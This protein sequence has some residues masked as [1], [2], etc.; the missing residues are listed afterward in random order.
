MIIFIHLPI[1]RVLKEISLLWQQT[2]GI[3]H[4][5]GHLTVFP[6]KTQTPPS[7]LSLHFFSCS[8][9]EVSEVVQMHICID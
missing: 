7:H 6:L 8:V 1:Y 5:D 2:N 9:E 4:L 3:N